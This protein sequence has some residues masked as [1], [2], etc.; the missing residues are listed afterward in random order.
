MTEAF[1]NAVVRF[2]LETGLSLTEAEAIL[3]GTG[4][5]PVDE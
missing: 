2:H 3:K 1:E 5:A 4:V